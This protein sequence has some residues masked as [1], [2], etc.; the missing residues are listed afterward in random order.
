MVI[1]GSQHCFDLLEC[2]VGGK[3]EH[4]YIKGQV[5]MIR[6]YGFVTFRIK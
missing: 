2:T 5:G 1:I 6:S 3:S 4:H